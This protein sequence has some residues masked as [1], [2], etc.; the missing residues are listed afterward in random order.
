MTTIGK[1]ARQH[2]LSRSTLLYYD[3]IGLLRPSARSPSGYR[4]Y[5]EA[6]AE[7][8][9]LICR[10]REAGIGLAVIGSML[11]AGDSVVVGALQDRLRELNDEIAGL[12]RQQHF[13][14]TLLRHAAVSDSP[15]VMT[16]ARWTAL[17][18]AA[19]MDDEAMMRWHAEFEGMAPD[20]HDHFLQSLGISAKEI[21]FIR[22][23]SRA[24]TVSVA[25][26][27]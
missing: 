11:D 19:G 27:R 26:P 12:R 18:R 17:L 8:L 10:Y 5:T 24:I 13:I 4:I 2:Q 25:A 14:V 16:K 22:E 20:A 1:L 15:A 21:A 7:R 23:A 9:R 3:R 6:D